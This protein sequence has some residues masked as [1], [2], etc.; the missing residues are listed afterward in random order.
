MVYIMMEMINDLHRFFVV[1]VRM[2]SSRVTDTRVSHV[3]QSCF[4]IHESRTVCPSIHPI[5]GIKTIS[6]K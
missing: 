1:V 4:R 5:G 6:E 3:C 2:I